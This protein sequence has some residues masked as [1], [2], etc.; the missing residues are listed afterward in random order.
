[1]GI[2]VG[3]KIVFLAIRPKLHKIN[4]G[5][6]YLP[7]CISRY[8]QVSPSLLI[9]VGGEEEDCDMEADMVGVREG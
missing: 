4:L 9:R 8:L 7:V 1:M 2:L 3:L 6:H 5:G